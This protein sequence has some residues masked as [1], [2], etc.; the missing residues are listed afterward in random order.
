MCDTSYHQN[1]GKF[2]ISYLFSVNS[3]LNQLQ[4]VQNRK[5]R[6]LQY[7]NKYFPINKMHKSY[8]ILKLQDII[9]YKEAKLSIH[10]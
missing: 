9:Q 6:A 1:V 5:L 4:V 8:E 2:D 3:D 10:F 7:K